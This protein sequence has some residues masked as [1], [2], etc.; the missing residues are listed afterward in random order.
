MT[1]EHHE[2]QQDAEGD[3]IPEDWKQEIDLSR[4]EPD[5]RIQGWA[6]GILL[7]LII[8]PVIIFLYNHFFPPK[9]PVFP[10]QIVQYVKIRARQMYHKVTIPSGIRSFRQ[11]I[12]YAHVPG[13]LKTLNVD[14]GDFVHKGQ[15][16]AY[17]QDPELQQSLEQKKAE[18]RI[19]YLT[20]RRIKRVWLSHPSLISEQRVQEKLAGYLAS[21]SSMRHDEALVAYKTI[22]A[23]FDGMITH[24][25][26]DQ[27]KLISQGTEQTVSVQP[28]VTLEQVD[29]LRAYVWVPSDV[30]PHIRR[31]QKVFARFAG[32]PG[33]TFEGRVTRFDA[34]ENQKT[35]TMRTEVD[36]KNP[37][38]E[39]HPGMYGQFTFYLEKLPR[40]I[41]VPGSAIRSEK[42]KGLTVATVLDGVVHIRPISIGIDNANWVQIDSGL[43]PGD[44]VVILGKW[45]VHEGEKVRAIPYK[46][47]PF[48]PARQL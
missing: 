44:R 43:S 35:R 19:R 18:V 5:H 33:K 27:G 2:Q 32:L 8:S 45:H 22:R 11:T 46:G 41:L 37:N 47:M 10:L 12:I 42:G 30:A 3:E 23:P 48:R 26:V 38:L 29:T 16:L 25:F 14:K 34:E 15:T 7:V 31:G 28:I 40:A 1:E 24:R 20:Y 6:G 4:V 21:V 39:I 9:P 36:I 13:Y 17:I